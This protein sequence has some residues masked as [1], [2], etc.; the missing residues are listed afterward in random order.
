MPTP[1]LVAINSAGADELAKLYAIGP[2][3]ARRIVADRAANGP[4]STPDDLARVE[5]VSAEL[6]LTLAP[7]IDWRRP[8]PAGG[9]PKE[10]AWGSALLF[11]VGALVILWLARDS[12]GD[13]LTGWPARA[14]GE[15]FARGGLVAALAELTGMLSATLALVLFALADLTRDRA[16]AK[17]LTRA[18]WLGAV[19]MVAALVVMGLA[20]AVYYQFYALD[21]WAGLV[22]NTGLMAALVAGLAALAL[23]LPIVAVLWRPALAY[24]AALARVVDGAL[25]VMSLAGIALS[26]LGRGEQPVFISIFS[27]VMGLVQAAIGFR[28]IRDGTPILTLMAEPFLPGPDERKADASA[29]LTWLNNRMPDREEQR[30]LQRALNEAYPPS[31]ARTLLGLIFFGAGGWL[32]LS[33]LQAVVGW[34]V[35]GWLSSWVR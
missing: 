32:V 2:A 21:G 1:S 25:L 22:G 7:H 13:V 11:A 18:G 15:P 8:Q 31:R 35:E 33:A 10:R 19:P 30:A 9:G 34:L 12:L 6:A 14:G 29:R 26:W 28:L 17:R 16:R 5:G 20:N 23:V 3:L 4:F 24:N 27:G